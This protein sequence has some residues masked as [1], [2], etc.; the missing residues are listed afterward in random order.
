MKEQAGD[1]STV[2]CVCVQRGC[3]GGREGVEIAMVEMSKYLEKSLLQLIP[4]RR[5]IKCVETARVETSKYLEK[6]LLQLM[7]DRRRI[8]CEGPRTFIAVGGSQVSD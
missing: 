6:S 7:P 3:G 2:L 8:K 5:R 1:K 4:D